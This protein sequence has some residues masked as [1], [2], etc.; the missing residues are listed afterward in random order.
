[1]EC[2]LDIHHAIVRRHALQTGDRARIRK[3]ATCVLHHRKYWCRRGDSN[4]HGLPHCPLKTACLPI[5]PRRHFRYQ[6]SGVRSR[7]TVAAECSMR[8]FT[9]AASALNAPP[10]ETPTILTSVLCLLTPVTSEP[11]PASALRSTAPACC[12]EPSQS[13]EAVALRM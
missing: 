4:S 3:C 10:P 7:R 6:E 2:G 9:R 11:P 12:W 8:A 1:I 5:S 13:G